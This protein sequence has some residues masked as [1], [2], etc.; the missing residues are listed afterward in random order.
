PLAEENGLIVEIGEVVLRKACF[1]AQN[2][3]RQKLF[4]GRVAVNLSSQQFA[5]PDLQQ[6]IE[7]ILRLTQLPAAN[8]ELEITEGTVIKQPEKAIKVMMQLSKMGVSLAL[9]DFGTGYSSLSY[10]KRFPIDTLKIDKAFVDDIDK[11]DRDLKMVDSIITI[12]HNMG[13]SVVGEGVEEASQLNILKALKCEE[14]QGFI[15][16]KAVDETCFTELLK[17]EIFSY[18][19]VSSH[20]KA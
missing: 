4:N 7:S 16:S 20:K 1:A 15:Y 5:L 8:L 12:A 6:R 2:W 9:D 11:S 14:I 18:S 3:R 17:Q 10:L 19:P 13:L